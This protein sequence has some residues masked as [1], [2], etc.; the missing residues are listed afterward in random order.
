MYVNLTFSIHTQKLVTSVL[1][2]L[3]IYVGQYEK[4]IYPSV[5]L[6]VENKVGG[7]H[8]CCVLMVLISIPLALESVVGDELS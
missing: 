6:H 3:L 2:S 4:G 8:Y 1:F 5:W 7:L